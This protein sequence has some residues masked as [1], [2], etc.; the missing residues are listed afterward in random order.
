M[1]EGYFTSPREVFGRPLTRDS[2]ALRDGKRLVEAERKGKG[3]PSETDQDFP[4][5][6]GAGGGPHQA[7]EERGN[8]NPGGK[9]V[10]PPRGGESGGETLRPTGAARSVKRTDLRGAFAKSQFGRRNQYSNSHFDGSGSVI[11]GFRL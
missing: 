9:S 10:G 2:V 4:R 5:V 1:T 6:A 3:G 7:R 8:P 11:F